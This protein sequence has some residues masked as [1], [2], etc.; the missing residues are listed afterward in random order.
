MGE[1]D[2]YHV[3]CD[4]SSMGC[5]FMVYGGIIT[6]AASVP[7]LDQRITDWRRHHNMNAELKWSKVSKAK[8]DKYIS[9]VDFFFQY[10]G[11]DGLHFKS[12]VFDTSQIDYKKHHNSDEELGF[13][14]FYYQFLLH[15]FAPYAES[16]AHRLLVCLDQKATAPER[17]STLKNVLNAGIRKKH[18]RTTDVV[19]AVEARVSHECNLIQIADVLMGAIAYHS[20]GCHREKIAS[21]HRCA[22]AEYIA[23]KAKL[24]NLAQATLRGRKDF[25]IWRFSFSAQAAKKRPAL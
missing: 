23:K 12:V 8:L 13:Y 22:L 18:G 14:K 3:Y 2:S 24:T 10:A 7:T 21:P 6:L 20:N 16:D 19:K 11:M 5:R 15:K 25:E 9:L 17:L 4:E 1:T